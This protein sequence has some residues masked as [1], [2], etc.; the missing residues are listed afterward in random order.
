MPALKLAA[1]AWLLPLPLGL[2]LICLGLVFRI[3]THRRA[4]SVLI[5][6]GT[7]VALAASLAP[8][9]YMLLRPLEARYPAVVDASALRP[10]PRY[11]AVLGSGYYPRAGLPVTAALDAVGVVRLAEG[12]RLLRQLPEAKLVVSG[13]PIRHEPAAIARGYALAATAL[14]VPVD[15]IILI[16]TPRDTATEIRALHTRI[17]D[18]A[19]LLVTSAAHMPR[20]MALSRREGL[21]ATA[22]PTGNLALGRMWST[23]PSGSSLR[24]SETALHEYEGLLALEM[25]IN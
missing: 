17:G 12:I 24:D 16:D 5:A 9:A 8:V 6:L 7:T 18:A 11:V 1:E 22:A 19:V 15:S 14:G 23:L 4:A 3:R 13:G 21:H 10:V 25:G 2:V 20:A